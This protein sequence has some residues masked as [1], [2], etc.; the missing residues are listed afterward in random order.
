MSVLSFL[1]AYLQAVCQGGVRQ[2][3]T[4][5]PSFT[6][7]VPL[8]SKLKMC[9]W[10]IIPG[11]SSAGHL[12]SASGVEVVISD[13]EGT[14]SIGSPVTITLFTMGHMPLNILTNYLNEHKQT[15]T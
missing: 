8:S 10:N 3:S 5:I 9:P 13:L 7:S 4:L 15:V 12:D 2:P 14:Q 6:N 1:S 11:N